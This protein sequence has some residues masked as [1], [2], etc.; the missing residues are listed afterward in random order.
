VRAALA[1]RGGAAIPANF[2]ATA[3]PYDPAAGARRGNMPRVD[4]RN[5]QTEALLA[6]LGLRWVVGGRVGDGVADAGLTARACRRG[7]QAECPLVGEDPRG[8]R[9]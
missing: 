3:L 8:L 6:M 9:G 2:V 5:P 4:A 7:V 1:A